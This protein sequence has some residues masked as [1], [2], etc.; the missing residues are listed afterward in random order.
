MS[1]IYI[2][3]LDIKKVMSELGKRSAAKLSPEQRIQR[4][5]KAVLARWAKRGII[6]EP[7]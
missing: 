1:K 7:N 2:M 4:A 3:D 5:K 6:K